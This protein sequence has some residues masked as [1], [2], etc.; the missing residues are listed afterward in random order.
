MAK[1]FRVKAKGIE[2]KKALELGFGTN[3]H[4][5]DF[6]EVILVHTCDKT[7]RA[8]ITHYNIKTVGE[9]TCG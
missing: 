9:I 5:C 8:M 1:F 7:M 6:D 3:Q 4:E 2:V